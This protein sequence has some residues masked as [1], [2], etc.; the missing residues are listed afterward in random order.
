MSK[1]LL[2]LLITV[3]IGILSTLILII[4]MTGD[5]VTEVQDMT[6]EEVIER[7]YTNY[8]TFNLV[9]EYILSIPGTFDVQAYPDGVYARNNI[10]DHIELDYLEAGK[11]IE[12]LVYDLGFRYIAKDETETKV[13]FE[14]RFADT[15]AKGIEYS[16]SGNASPWLYCTI[17]EIENWCYYAIPGRE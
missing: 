16:S 1:L 8:D 10:D 4:S 15:S 11:Y 13:F 3:I 14:M 17:L 6:Q 2:T 12:Y 7:F 9:A 5:S